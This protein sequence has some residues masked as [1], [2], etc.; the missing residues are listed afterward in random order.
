[1]LGDYYFQ[2]KEYDLAKQSYTQALGL[3]PTS[4]EEILL[5]TNLQKTLAAK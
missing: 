5:K 3:A 2:H 4:N 1:V